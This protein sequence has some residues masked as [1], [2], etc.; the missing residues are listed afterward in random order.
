M[1]K[2]PSSPRAWLTTFGRRCFPLLRLRR[3]ISFARGVH[4]ADERAVSRV[5]AG[6]PHRAAEGA[7]LRLP[8][9]R[10]AQP[11]AVPA[12]GSDR[13]G[14][15]RGHH[16]RERLRPCH[17]LP[18]LPHLRARPAGGRS[19]ERRGL[20]ARR[21]R[22]VRHRLLVLVR[23]RAH[24]GR[25]RDPPQHHGLQ[26]AHVPDGRAVHARRAP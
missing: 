25:H 26:R 23:V 14:R 16:L 4:G 12:A 2:F 11:Q 10:A 20:L 18:A 3:G 7:S 24:R 6:E 9:V 19:G 21:P 17:R 1:L 8:A 5:C 13:G 15:A 22:V